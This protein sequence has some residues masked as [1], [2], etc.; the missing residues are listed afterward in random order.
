MRNSSATPSPYMAASS[1]CSRSS[2]NAFASGRSRK[3]TLKRP[4]SSGTNRAENATIATPSSLQVPRIYAQLPTHVV[5]GT[6]RDIRTHVRNDCPAAVE[7]Q[8]CVISLAGGFIEHDPQVTLSREPAQPPDE[9]ATRHALDTYVRSQPKKSTP[10]QRWLVAHSGAMWT[11]ASIGSS[12]GRPR[13]R[14]AAFSASM[15]VGALRLP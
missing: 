6:A 13:I 11:G 3:M 10:A 2:P 15:M 12:G 4:S 9:L 1:A 8:R 5:E 7:I 14:S